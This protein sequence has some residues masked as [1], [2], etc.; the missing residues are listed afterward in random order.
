GDFETFVT[1]PKG[2]PANFLT[3]EEFRG[4][5]DG[6]CQPYLDGDGIERLADAVLSLEQAN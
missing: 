1:V 3:D 2:E 5:F 4:K 6:L